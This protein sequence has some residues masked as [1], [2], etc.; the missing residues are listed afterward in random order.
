VRI[1]CALLC[2]AA[3]V[4]EGLLHVLGGG[5]TRA[6]RSAYPAPVAL[7][8]ALRILIHPT[9]A[10]RPHKLVVQLQGVDGQRIANFEV[11]F[12][13][14]DPGAVD[15]AEQISIPLPLAIPP[16]VQLPGAGQYSFELLIDGIHQGSVPFVATE[17]Q[18]EEAP[19]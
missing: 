4:R 14:N 3:T 1:D 13:V 2:D 16:A 10:D 17:L 8:L 5:V 18:V 19:G 15:P 7:T 12:G 9:E 11:E 6:N